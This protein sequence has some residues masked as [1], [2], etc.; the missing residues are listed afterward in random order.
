VRR[1]T[2]YQ[3]IEEKLGPIDCKKINLLS[4]QYPEAN[5]IINTRFCSDFATEDAI[6]EG[7][8]IDGVCYKAL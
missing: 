5:M 6:N 8:T 3:L 7:I 2:V 1:A 4:E